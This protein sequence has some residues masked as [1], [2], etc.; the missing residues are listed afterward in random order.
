MFYVEDFYKSFGSSDFNSHGDSRFEKL[1]DVGLGFSGT[2][3]KKYWSS[4][5]HLQYF[6]RAHN[7]FNFFPSENK[8]QKYSFQKENIELFNTTYSFYSKKLPLT[9]FRYSII[10][11]WMY[12]IKPPAW[13]RVIIWVMWILIWFYCIIKP[14]AGV[15]VR[16]RFQ[17]LNIWISE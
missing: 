9:L 7:I 4:L 1:E 14:L 8:K 2:Q 10:Y 17:S 16:A 15:R 11:I 12:H 3:K 13:V 6:L 5:N